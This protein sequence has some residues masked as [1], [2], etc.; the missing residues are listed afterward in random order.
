MCKRQE[1]SGSITV[2]AALSLMLIASFLLALLEQARY[3]GLHAMA[4]MV[5]ENALESLLSEYDRDLFDRYGIFLLDAGFES[6]ELQF[7]MLDGRLL[8]NSQMNLRPETKN[9]VVSRLSFSQN[10]YQMDVT[11]AQLVR[12]VLATDANGEPFRAMAAQSMK[13]R[14]PTELLESLSNQLNESEGAM[15][16]ANNSRSSMDA[17]RSDLTQAKEESA[18]AA[19]AAAANATAEGVDT[20]PLQPASNPPDNPMD[21][22]AAV[23]GKDIL[24]LVLPAGVAVSNKSIDLS[25]NLEHR[26]LVSGNGSWDHASDFFENVLYQKFLQAN[27]SCFTGDVIS[28]GTLDYELEYIVAGKNTDRANLKSVVNRLLLLREGVNFLYLQT[29]AAK[30]AQAYELATAIAAAFAVAPAIPL[31]AQGILAAWAYAE[32]IL[33]VRTLMAG[34]KVPWIKTA[35]SWNSDLGSIASYL[36]GNSQAKTSETGEDYMGYLEK[37]LYLT[38]ERASNY[39]AMDMM[40]GYHNSL[41]EGRISMDAMILSFDAAFCYEAKPIF[42]DMVTLSRLQTDSFVFSEEMTGNYLYE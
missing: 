42:S 23:Q 38:P 37:L 1:V 21:A 39:R 22:V 26:Y 15:E 2:F 5:R 35:S 32:S 8:E 3:A 12:Y 33:D 14:Y 41:G 9:G 20:K 31:L 25:K 36:A 30:Y 11:Q 19:A 27:F 28:G 6:G 40:E 16:Q 24:T 4:S 10:F 7:S 13:T 34:G 17:A 18:Q 29:D